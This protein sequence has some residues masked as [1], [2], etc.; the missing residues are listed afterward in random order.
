MADVQDPRAELDE[1]LVRL[2]EVDERID[3]LQLD[4]KSIRDRITELLRY[5]GMDRL[6]V[7][8]GDHTTSLRLT[9]RTTVKYDEDALRDRLGERYESILEPDMKRVRKHLPEVGHLLQPA[10]DV[11]GAPSRELVEQ[12][13]LEGSLAA[14]DFSGAFVKT[15]IDVLYV[16]RQASAPAEEGDARD[17]DAPY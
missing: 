17:E 5:L 15:T 11:V 2:H 13:I 10:L 8:A 7:D 3:A 6:K 12:R 4:R 1:L 16:R 14:A 9:R